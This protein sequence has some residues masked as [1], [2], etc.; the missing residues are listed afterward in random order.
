[1]EI[2]VDEKD[3]LKIARDVINAKIGFRQG[4]GWVMQGMLKYA[5]DN[6]WIDG[7]TLVRK[8]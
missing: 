1:M 7:Y 6:G 2:K 3:A 5:K 8:V 4:F